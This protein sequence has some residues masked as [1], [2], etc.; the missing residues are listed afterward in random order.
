M[1]QRQRQRQGQ[2]NWGS[3]LIVPA[4]QK[5]DG[6]WVPD[7]NA[8][9]NTPDWWE[10]GRDGSYLYQQ[11]PHAPAYRAYNN[12][13]EVHDRYSD[14]WEKGS[15]DPVN[16][17]Q[18]QSDL[19]KFRTIG[20]PSTLHRQMDAERCI[21]TNLV[22][23]LSESPEVAQVVNPTTKEKAQISA[24]DLEHKPFEA[25]VAECQG[26]VPND[27]ITITFDH[28]AT[29]PD[30]KTSIMQETTILRNKATV[31]NILRA[32]KCMTTFYPGSIGGPTQHQHFVSLCKVADRSWKV[33]ASTSATRR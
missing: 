8:W 12:Q 31:L 24:Q 16:D 13:F 11:G 25:D 29:T 10:K 27:L 20:A 22:W 5:D 15:V 30:N 6:Q 2:A 17:F 28:A 18:K 26:Y 1:A 14:K 4:V 21:M 32:I 19:A 23:K 7:M 33:I 3:G 9:S